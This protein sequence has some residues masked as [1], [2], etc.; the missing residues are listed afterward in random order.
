MLLR[1]YSLSE[2]DRARLGCPEWL[3]VDLEDLPI[4]DCIDLESTG[5]D[6]SSVIDGGA[7]GVK[8]RVWLA[9]RRAGV[10]VPYSELTFNITGLRVE[11]VDQP[12]GAGDEGKDE[13]SEP[14]EP[15][16]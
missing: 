4:G 12:D 8:G 13:P 15:T 3:E 1:R 10:D 11:R 2:S 9:L 5:G 6:W 7:K 16:T 14:S